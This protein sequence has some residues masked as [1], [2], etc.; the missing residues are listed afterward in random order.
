MARLRLER[1]RL[2]RLRLGRVSACKDNAL[3]QLF[4]KTLASVRA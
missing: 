4:S 1:L 2:E 3:P